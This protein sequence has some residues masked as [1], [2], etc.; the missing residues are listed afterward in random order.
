MQRFLL[1]LSF[2]GSDNLNDFDLSFKY[3]VFVHFL[4]AQMSP[5]PDLPFN[6]LKDP[7]YIGRYGIDYTFPSESPIYEW[8]VST[9][10]PLNSLGSIMPRQRTRTSYLKWKRG[11]RQSVED[12]CGHPNETRTRRSYFKAPASFKYSQTD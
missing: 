10:L 1:K 9:Q 7:E 6:V 3:R 5:S 4:V 12:A 11:I 2:N 8:N